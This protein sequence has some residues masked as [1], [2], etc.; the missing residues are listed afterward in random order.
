MTPVQDS[1]RI[2]KNLWLLFFSFIYTLKKIIEF[3]AK[4]HTTL[5]HAQLG[6]QQQTSQT[7]SLPSWT[8]HNVLWKPVSP[9][10][11][12]ISRCA[13]YWFQLF[14]LT[15]LVHCPVLSTSSMLDSHQVHIQWAPWI[16]NNLSLGWD[17]FIAGQAWIN[18]R[19]DGNLC[20]DEVR[21]SWRR[22]I[23]D[24]S[25][26]RGWVS[27]TRQEMWNPNVKARESRLDCILEIH[28]YGVEHGHEWVKKKE[29]R[30]VRKQL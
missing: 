8:F 27:C 11:D 16:Q 22:G 4:L 24:K 14:L 23:G 6:V 2:F 28:L 1:L 29:G 25:E 7:L 15:D 26:K 5:Y 19:G 30:P 3:C 10:G 13:N 20:L 9:M 18:S 12:I 17:E 21:V